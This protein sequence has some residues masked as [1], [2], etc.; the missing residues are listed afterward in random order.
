[1]KTLVVLTQYKRDNL[2]KQLL[3]IRNQTM[4]PDYVVV[5][6]NENHKD[7]SNL[8]K[9]FNFIHIKSDYNTK[10]F[11][12]FAYCVTFPV[13]ICFV[14]DD[15]I[16]PGN[17][18]LKNYMDQCI[19]LNAIIGGNGRIAMNNPNKHKLK[20]PSDIGV[21]KENVMV[22]FVGHIWCFKKDWLYFMFGTKPLTFDTGEDMHLCFTSKIFGNINSFTSKQITLDDMADI[23]N[24]T[25]AIDQYSSYLTTPKTLR[26][27]VETYFLEQFSI[28]FIDSN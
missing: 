3:Q 19:S 21:R 16:I 22:D 6:Q 9:T 28:T 8:K 2:E 10:F 7:I 14:L 11:G 23:T 13:D 5:F 24:N 27:N 17:N 26:S 18:C 25:L 4:K 20:H 12:R 15:D 1:M